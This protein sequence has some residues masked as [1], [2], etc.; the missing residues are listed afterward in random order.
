ME[1]EQRTQTAWIVDMCKSSR[2]FR[3][4]LQHLVG[5]QHEGTAEETAQA[6]VEWVAD[7][8]P[9]QKRRRGAV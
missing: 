2:L 9:Q 7:R 4:S 8:A 3:T 5:V 6:F 1:M